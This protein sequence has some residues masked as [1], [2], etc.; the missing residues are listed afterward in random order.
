[1]HRTTVACERST[2][3]EASS[4]EGLGRC[5][6]TRQGATLLGTMTLDRA[7]FHTLTP[8]AIH[9]RRTTRGRKDMRPVHGP[10]LKTGQPLKEI[11]FPM[12]EPSGHRGS[13]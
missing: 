5:P 11:E 7:P 9:R 8:R 4:R 10:S 13:P 1:M 6:G 2:M 12:L 3:A